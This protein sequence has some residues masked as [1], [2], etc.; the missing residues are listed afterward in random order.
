M[1]PEYLNIETSKKPG[2]RISVKISIPFEGYKNNIE[3]TLSKLSKTLKIPGFRAG[4]V[5]KQVV[6]QQLGSKQISASSLESIM[7]SS[8]KLVLKEK[9][10]NP[11]SEPELTNNFEDILQAMQNKKEICFTLE[12]DIAPNPKLKKTK[13]LVFNIETEEF[14][15]SEIDNFI[16][17]SRDQFA[18]LVPISD[19]SAQIGDV[20]V[21]NFKGFYTKTKKEIEGGSAES[22]DIDLKEG[23]MIPGF[24]EGIVGM[25][26][27]EE[28]T[29]NLIFPE[30][31]HHEESKGKEATFDITLKDLKFRELPELNDEF[32]KQASNKSTLK[33]FKKEVE[34][35]LKKE[36]QDKQQSSERQAILEILSL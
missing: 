18:T 35:N 30:N 15:K 31:Y 24:I 9:A 33:E 21:V 23:Q 4:K 29:L 14:N 12:T 22:M 3:E 25:N 7:D 2:S 11:L 26:I 32:A 36:F 10:I 5:P 20:A 28:K 19:R 16:E 17:K 34:E 27:N 13:D 8:W 1:K 6:I